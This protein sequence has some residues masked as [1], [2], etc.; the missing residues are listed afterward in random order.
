MRV[1][2]IL[3]II[4]LAVVAW[5]IVERIFFNGKASGPNQRGISVAVEIA[6][7]EKG[8]IRDIGRYTGS[9]IPKST[10]MV[11]PKISGRLKQLLV[12]IGDPV[13]KD[14]LVAVVEDEEY[15]HQV[16]QAESDLQVA[17]A[18]LEQ[19]ESSLETAKREMERAKSLHQ[20]GIQSDSELETVISQFDAQNAK[21]KVAVAQV[22]NREAA[23]QTARIRL[24]YT[25]IRASW[26][27]GSDL[28]YVGERFVDEGALLSPNTS[29]LSII[30]LQPIIAVIHVTDREYFRL[31]PDSPA[32]ITSIAYP[33]EAFNGH[34]ARIAPLL[35]ET[36]REARVEIE[37]DNSR[38]H[39]KPGM[40]VNAQIEFARRQA[41]AIVPMSALVTRSG[42][43]GVFLADIE[44]KKAVYRAVRV[45][46]IEADRAEIL[47]PPLGEGFVVTLG[48]HL[49]EDGT[50]IILPQNFAGS[51]E[52]K[53]E[54]GRKTAGD[55][56]SGQAGKR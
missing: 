25:R 14:Q 55:V 20:K 38:E 45:G 19:A 52:A 31:K 42:Q 8:G 10:F 54:A 4:F 56:A 1:P 24:S 28:R 3:A 13:R 39:L 2:A 48:H 35:K 53:P 9:L 12:N 5:Q 44:N 49:L 30:E 7:I 46:I 40:F 15:Q 47:E 41:T 36:S 17:K 29:I 22:S 18:N 34:V 50:T 27:K 43:Q 21:H 37:I 23:L 11:A 32:A 26:E 51:N 16:I 6:P 33:G